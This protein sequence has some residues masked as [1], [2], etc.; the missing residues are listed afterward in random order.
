MKSFATFILL[1]QFVLPGRGQKNNSDTLI[2][3]GEPQQPLNKKKLL[4]Y[5]AGTA[6]GWGASMVGL[7]SL[8]YKDYGTGKFHFFDDSKEWLQMDKVG[9]T[10][11]SYYVGNAA[12]NL[13][14][15]TGWKR[16][17]C[18][19]WGG[20]LGTFFLSSVE[21]FDGYSNGW[22]FSWSDMGANVAGSGLFIGQEFLWKEQRFTLKFSAHHTGYAI[23]RPELL[24]TGG[25]E[26]ILKDYN[27]QTYWLSGN[28]HSFMR[29]DAKFPRWL[30]I[31]I[32][33]GARGMIG[34]MEN[35]FVPVDAFMP[36]DRTREWYVSLDAD[37]WRIKT[38]SKFLKTVF[39]AIGFI[40]IPFPTLEFHKNGLSFYP[41][42]F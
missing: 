33:Y 21:I 19:V 38:R 39:K 40:K 42:Y 23:Y 8:W 9:H 32:G 10:M 37:L 7:Y 20:L 36:F 2:V 31:S 1:L 4:W 35:P 27:G 5:S 3:V 11:T 30:S 17:R 29:E 41:L 26:R 22:G 25:L 34:G 16:N 13:L 14:Y 12:C 28:L 15:T 24:G 18:I 6:A